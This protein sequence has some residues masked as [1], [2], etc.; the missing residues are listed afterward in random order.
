MATPK[1]LVLQLYKHWEIVEELARMSREWPAFDEQTVLCIISKLH[2]APDGEPDKAADALR[3]LCKCDVL[4][5]LERTETLQVNPVVLEF[6]RSLTREHELG[7]SSVLK[8][9]VDGIKLAIMQTSEGMEPFNHELIRQGA[10]H[11]SDLFRQ[12]GLQLDVDR[13]AIMDL[14]EQAKSSDSAQPIQ[15]RYRAVL[16]ACV[17][18][19]S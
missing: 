17:F 19:R 11:L 6:V 13:H 4:Q 15:Y 18:R 2:C 1:G 9:R 8:A 7:L 5:C 10:A 3:A 12:I 16:E 14:A